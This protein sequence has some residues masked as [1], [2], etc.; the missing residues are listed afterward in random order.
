MIFDPTTGDLSA[1]SKEVPVSESEVQVAKH[2]L[3]TK[4]SNPV[5]TVSWTKDPGITPGDDSAVVYLR[6]ERI[7]WIEKFYGTLDLKTPPQKHGAKGSAKWSFEAKLPHHL[8]EFT[9]WTG[10]DYVQEY[11]VPGSG[12][13]WT[14]TG[15]YPASSV[16]TSASN[17][18]EEI[19]RS[20]ELLQG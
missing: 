4:G 10:V 1:G 12:G 2:P 5:V 17:E 19:L 11:I 20:I 13:Y 7:P 14:I 15:I 16:G 6:E 3:G 18:V 9:G 8:V